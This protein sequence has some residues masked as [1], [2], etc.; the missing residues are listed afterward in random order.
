MS[1]HNAQIKI[2]IL[3]TK[4]LYAKNFLNTIMYFI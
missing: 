3:P 1:I 4:K 2:Y